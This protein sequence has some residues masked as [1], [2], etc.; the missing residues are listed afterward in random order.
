MNPNHAFSVLLVF[1]ALAGFAA[2]STLDGPGWR[3][4]VDRTEGAKL[5]ASAAQFDD[6]AWQPVEVPHDWAIAG[7]FDPQANGG[8]GKLCWE[9]VGWYRRTFDMP[10]AFERERSAGGRILLIF[11][12]VMAKPEVWVNG[13]KAGGWDY[14][15]MG[16]TLDV[17]DLLAPAGNVLAVRADSRGHQTRWYPGGGL[18]RSVTLRSVP[19]DYVLPGTVFIRPTS[20]DKDRAV[21]AVSYA[22]AKSGATNETLVIEKPRLWDVDDPHLY[23][24]TLDGATCRYGLR[25]AEWTADDGFH[26]NGR[27]V[28]L[29][30]ACLHSDLGPLGMAFN[31]SAAR[32]QLETMKDM[33]VNAIRTSHNCPDPKFLDLCDEMGFLVWDEAFDSGVRASTTGR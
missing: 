23:T 11:D 30:G 3:F 16:F 4:C 33:G 24:M 5:D 13:R 21:V 6:T 20:L 32:R 27:R 14:G 22:R 28:Q 10:S 2:E 15:Y 17:T 12:G 26:L 31:V 25:T 9:Q 19:A 7:P 8:T 29:K 1:S 18:Y